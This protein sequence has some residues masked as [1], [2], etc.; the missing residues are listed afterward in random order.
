MNYFERFINQALQKVL[1]LICP[2][3]GHDIYKNKR[4][5]YTFINSIIIANTGFLENYFYQKDK[6]KDISTSCI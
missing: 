3:K 6:I 2:E 5:S 4:K 1:L